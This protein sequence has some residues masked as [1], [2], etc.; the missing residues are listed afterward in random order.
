MI[1]AEGEQSLGPWIM[2]G[3]LVVIVGGDRLSGGSGPLL[4]PLDPM[5]LHP[6]RH[7]HLA[8]DDDVDPQGES[9]GHRPQQ[10]HGRAG[11]ADAGLSDHDACA[12]GALSGGR[13]R[14]QCHSRADRRPS[15][16]HRSR[17]ADG[18]GDR[19]GGARPARGRSHERLSESHRLSRSEAIG[20]NAWT[21]SPATAF[22]SSRG[23]A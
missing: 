12:G 15:R 3:G 1:L 8:T 23:P 17:L 19:P 14:S 10:D 11:R 13:Q 5:H 2:L 6:G 21:P 7:Q 22:G 18:P 4:Q 16:A 20:R 9:D